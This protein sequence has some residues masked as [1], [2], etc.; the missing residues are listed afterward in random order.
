M[1]VFISVFLVFVFTLTI[2]S[3]ALAIR[4]RDLLK[5]AVYSA[6]ESLFIGLIYAAMLAMDLALVQIACGVGLL[7]VL[8]V[9]A[10]QKTSRYE[11]G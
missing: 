7:T 8:F 5:A 4:E 10:I 2:I 3:T 1:I 9:F 6:A 11:K